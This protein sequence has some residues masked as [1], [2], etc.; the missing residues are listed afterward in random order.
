MKRWNGWG[1][2]ATLYPLPPAAESYLAAVVGP[3]QPTPDAPLQ[4]VLARVPHSWL[5]PHPLITTA[6]DER[7][8]HARGQ[9]LPD[10][11]ELRSG[12][13]SSFPDGVAYPQTDEDIRALLDYAA[14]VGAR[15]IPY[16]GGSSV[17]GHINPRESDGLSLTVDL[18]RM[19]ALLDFDETSLVATFGAGVP[20]PKLEAD[21][22]A[23]G[24]TLGH[25]PQSFEYSTLGG[26]VATRSTGQQSYYYGRIE[27]LFLGGHVESPAGALDFPVLPASAA[28]PDLRQFFLGSEGRMGILTRAAVRVRRR[29]QVERFRAI[30]FPDWASGAA[31]VCEMAQARLGVSMLRLS[32]AQETETTLQLSGKERLVSLAH[33]GLS[34]IGQGDERCLLIYGVTGAARPAALAEQAVHEIARAHRGFAVNVV[35]G[36]MW[37]KSRF[38]TPYLRN[39]LWERG[40]ALDTLE[41]A[42]PWSSVLACNREAKEAL[43]AALAECGER[44]LVFSHLSHVYSEGASMYVTYLWR[45]AADP[46]ETL[47][48]WQRMKAAASQVIVS[49][50]GTISHQHGVGLDHKP[51]L[52]AEK[53]RLGLALIGA[54]CRTADPDG[55]MNPGKLVD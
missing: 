20:G 24:C 30:F 31:A 48:R 17:L 27:P 44:A 14:G 25:F 7:L 11:V 42:L 12:Q 38:L 26:W 41:T 5:P 2:E 13:V 3:G 16:G 39:T 29:P 8:R 34:R 45:R 32:D 52:A 10:W 46:Q 23:R 21:L 53:G 54:A 43:R 6:E 47:A 37:K 36:D 40:Y 49:H 35:I 1:N 55:L 28:G 19:D 18:A 4:D 51:Y 50:G 22:Q 15:L 33:W 9:S